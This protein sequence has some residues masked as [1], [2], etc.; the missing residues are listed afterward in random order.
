MTEGASALAP[1]LYRCGL[2]DAILSIGGVQN[3]TIG[4]AAMKAL[5]IGVP[6]LMVST[7]ASGQRSLLNRWWE[8][9]TSSCCPRS[10]TL[11]ELMC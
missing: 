9:K 3:T 7:V 2:F 8:A 10:R 1:E 6:K 5:P 11:R 4:V